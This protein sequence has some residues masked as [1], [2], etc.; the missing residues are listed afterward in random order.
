M[1]ITHRWFSGSL[2][3]EGLDGAGCTQAQGHSIPLFVLPLPAHARLRKPTL[4]LS[5]PSLP[6]GPLPAIATSSLPPLSHSSILCFIIPLLP[7]HHQYE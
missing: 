1:L 6:A 7:F 4:H 2:V 5:L 3:G